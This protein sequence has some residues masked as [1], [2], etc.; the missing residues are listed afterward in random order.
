MA[1]VRSSRP[2]CSSP[3]PVPPLVG[4]VLPTER[5]VAVVLPSVLAVVEVARF[6]RRPSWR[7]QG[8]E[9]EVVVRFYPRPS[10]LDLAEEEEAA[11]LRC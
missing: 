7:V 5:A 2:R 1:A 4:E 10:S 3:W 11:A 8:E 6:C 9:E